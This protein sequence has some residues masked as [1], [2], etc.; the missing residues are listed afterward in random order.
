ML[1][2]IVLEQRPAIPRS[3]AALSFTG[4]IATA[5]LLSA[6]ILVLAGVPASLLAEELVVQVF[7]TSD[8]LAQTLTLAI[9]LTLAGLSAAMA[10]RV[11]F[12]NIGIEGQVLLGAI[13]A[14]AVAV[15]DLGPA[16]TRLPVMLAMAAAAGAAWIALPLLLKLRLGV[17]E[18]VVSLLMANIAFLLLQHLLFG[19]LR[20]PSANF[21][22]SPTFDAPERLAGFGWGR[23]HAGL[24]LAV[25]AAVLAAVFVHATRPG[26]YAR[27]VGSGPAAARAAGLPVAGTVVGFA[28]LS[29]A[30]AGLAGG[31]IVAGTEHRLTQF[32]GLNTT[33]SGIVVAT[34]AALEPLGVVIAAFLVAG[35]YV[36]GGTLK[37][38]YG[39]SEGVVVLIQGVVL[40]T[41]LIGRFAAA[42]RVTGLGPGVRR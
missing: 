25:V 35:V 14:T 10:F 11:G 27:V 3:L 41:F 38:F 28:L 30:L 23:V 37:V 31:I 2:R 15:A 16:P 18:I 40:M 7:L 21:P 20:D 1:E 19:S 39:V 26:F 22:V 13:A 12:W 9:P 29:G 6:L 42:Y 5:I 32:V 33:F 8:G 17:S 34:L 24:Y 4:A 36:A